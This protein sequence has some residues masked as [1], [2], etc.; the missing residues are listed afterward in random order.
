MKLSEFKQLIES[1]VYS[2]MH[3]IDESDA[4]EEA[5]KLNLVH[6]GFG[7]YA[8]KIGGAITHKTIDGRLV[9]VGARE[10]AKDPKMIKKTGEEPPDQSDIGLEDPDGIA[11]KARIQKAGVTDI[12]LVDESEQI[13]TFRYNGKPGRI[14]LSKEELEQLKVENIVH[15]IEARIQRK[16]ARLKIQKIQ[17]S[18]GKTI[19]PP[20]A[21]IVA[22]IE[23]GTK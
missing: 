19:V 22:P 14:K 12:E 16:I 4:S 11:K 1:E 9:Y 20:K 2:V 23:K 7:N 6:L 3:D 8:Q 5:K 21:P 10:P 18:Q 15:I 13:Y 17:Q